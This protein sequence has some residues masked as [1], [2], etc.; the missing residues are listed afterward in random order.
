MKLTFYSLS[1]ALSRNATFSNANF[2]LVV[3]EAI[4]STQIQCQYTAASLRFNGECRNASR[5]M[6]V[7]IKNL[8]FLSCGPGAHSTLPAALFF[9]N[10]CHIQINNTCVEKSHGVGLA[11][12]D[13]VG[14]VSV[15]WS[16]FSQN[17]FRQGFGGGVHLTI[18]SLS[19]KTEFIHC[20]FSEN[21]VIPLENNETKGGGLYVQY[22]NDSQNGILHIINCEFSYNQAQWGGGLLAMFNDN[23]YNNTL[24]INSTIFNKNCYGLPSYNENMAGAGAAVTIYS[25]ATSNKALIIDCNF[26]GNVAPWGGGLMIFTKPTRKAVSETHNHLNISGCLFVNNSAHIGA[27]MHIYC[28]S[29]ASS[30]QQCNAEPV[31]AQSVFAHNTDLLLV[32]ALRQS[33]HSIVYIGHFPTVL[34]KTLEFSNNLGT[35]LH[36]HETSVSLE[37]DTVL[38]FTENSAQNGG[39]I[40]L[41]G[42]WIAVSDN[43]TL[44]FSNNRARERGAAIY[45]FMTEEVYI[46]YSHHCFIKSTLSS[47]PTRWNVCFNFSGNAYYDGEPNAIYATS[48][49]PC[50]LHGGSSPDDDIR[51]T[52]C[53]WKNWHF[54][55]KN[56]CID[57]IQTSPRNFSL[58]LR[59]MSAFPGIPSQHLIYAED[60]LGHNVTYIFVYSTVLHPKT[61][62]AYVTNRTL[63]VH[64]NV[65]TNV[66]IQLELAASRTLL[67]TVNVSL[68]GCPPGFSFDSPSQSCICKYTPHIYCGYGLDSRWIA[69]IIAGFCMSYSPIKNKDN[70]ENH[71]VFGQCPFT[72]GLESYSNHRSHYVLYLPLPLEKEELDSKFCRKLNRTGILCGKC[73]A[74][75][76]IDLLSSTFQ[77]HNCSGSLMKWLIYI[78]AEGIPPLIF[79]VIVLVLHISLTSGPLNGFIFFCQVLTVSVEVMLLQ[80]SWMDSSI[81]DPDIFS[82]LIIKAYSVWSLDFFRSVHGYYRIC[83]GTDIKAMHVL[84]LRY[85]SALYPLCFLLIA[86][87]V[88]E[89]HARNCRLLVWLWK[90]LCFV[91][92]RFRQAWKARTSIVDAFA[93]FILLSYVKIVRISLLLVTYSTVSVQ[94]SHKTIKVINYDPT[95]R[96]L[97]SEHVPFWFLATACLLTF[98]FVPPVLLTFYQFKFFQRCLNRCKMNGNGLRIFLDAFQGCYKDGREGGPDRR[99]FAGLYFIFRL[100]V[101]AIFDV[102]VTVSYAYISLLMAFV[103]FGVITAVVQPYKKSF[104]TY[105][106]V[107]FFNLLATIMALQFLTLYLSTVTDYLPVSIVSLTFTL[108]TIPLLYVSLFVLYWVYGRA[109]KCAKRKVLRAVQSIKRCITH[110]T[111]SPRPIFKDYCSTFSDYVSDGIPDRLEHSYRYRSL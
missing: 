101:F 60:D 20:I 43:N 8:K 100:F 59:D 16:N 52:F 41:Y 87:T 14:R 78:T 2:S 26:T 70:H 104:L 94:D 3:L 74:N 40:T 67:M 25:N 35:P 62:T 13:V 24:L 63:T 65:N 110:F 95:V 89:L 66:S 4:S 93:A 18:T 73:I 36:V 48:V 86:F 83:L 103:I 69:Y 19:E 5:R 12:V 64:G 49:L 51:R 37:T 39:A 106:D 27:A 79:F 97:S 38:N 107:F 92:A 82:S 71:V 91:C 1:E 54:G 72:A 61:A 57:Q 68:Q 7:R 88:I 23:S 21:R 58:T 32:S 30:P 55:G 47:D 28:L 75:Y 84:V 11:I 53:T 10:N 45:S 81:R 44:L 76:S 6:D 105:L 15:V 9:N 17:V 80:A 99:Y 56:K 34:K 108:I 111:G 98:G 109:P 29:P 90:P 42:S 96:Y 85:L 33:P 46:P 102:S 22:R 50:V 31:V 77:C